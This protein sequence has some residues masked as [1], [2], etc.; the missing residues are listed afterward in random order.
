MFS[1]FRNISAECPQTQNNIPK[2]KVEVWA[3]NGQINHLPVIS[4]VTFPPDKG[5]LFFIPKFI[6]RNEHLLL[7]K[8]FSKIASDNEALSQKPQWLT[9]FQKELDFSN[10]CIEQI[11]KLESDIKKLQKRHFLI[12]AKSREYNNFTNLLYEKDWNLIQEVINAFML[13]DFNLAESPLPLKNMESMFYGIGPGNQKIMV[14]VESAQ[15][16]PVGEEAYQMLADKMKECRIGSNVKGIIIA[17]TDFLRSP[18]RRKEWFSEKLIAVSGKN[19]VCLIPTLQLFRIV[20]LV[21]N[22]S[23][24]DMVNEIKKSLRNEILDCD[25]LFKFNDK[26]YLARPSSKVGAF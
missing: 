5:E 7:A 22:R 11:K 18:N 4:R 24:S 21:L 16:N 2:G 6:H 26:K 1:L 25:G 17:N 12:S 10:P 8:A 20:C 19:D 3:N 23:G 13:L 9:R 15:D 14:N